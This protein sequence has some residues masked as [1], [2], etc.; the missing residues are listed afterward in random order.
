M[1]DLDRIKNIAII[2][3]GIMGSGIAQVALL[4]GYE[5]V[6]IVDLKNDILQKS[7]ETIQKRI[8]ALE[9]EENFKKFLLESGN[10]TERR[11]KINFNKK[12]TEFKSVGII[13]NR[14]NKSTIM[15]RLK[16]ETD[17]SK[18][19]VDADFVIEA[20]PEILITKQTVFKKLG[21][22]SPPYTV[23]ASNTST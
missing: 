20:V 11:E 3:G 19:V 15:S 6:T 7:K 14:I 4:T 13:A 22:F 23:L 17:I 12:L 9:S 21:E 10:S 5:K 18:G 8:V 2:G 16:T 1:D